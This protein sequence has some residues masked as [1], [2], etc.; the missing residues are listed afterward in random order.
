MRSCI[1]LLALSGKEPM[2]FGGEIISSKEAPVGAKKI[3]K[4]L[5]EEILN[6]ITSEEVLAY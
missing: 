6:C 3:K 2:L 5:I 4:D 1:G